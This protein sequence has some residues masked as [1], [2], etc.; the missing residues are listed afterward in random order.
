MPGEECAFTT[1]SVSV[2]VTPGTPLR[3]V[4][5]YHVNRF[6]IAEADGL[7][8]IADLG[9]VLEAAGAFTGTTVIYDGA[10]QAVVSAEARMVGEVRAVLAAFDW[11]HDDRQL[12]LEAI[13]R[14]DDED[15]ADEPEDDHWRDYNYACS[16]CGA[17]IGMFIGRQGWAALPRRRHCGQPGRDLRRRPRGHVRRRTGRCAVTGAWP[18]FSLCLHGLDAGKIRLR[19]DERHN[20]VPRSRRGRRDPG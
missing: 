19:R 9:A 2:P 1:V 3:R 5:G 12:A 10:P 13:E 15:Q 14:I 17:L 16:T 6:A 8:T 4:R 20:A 18:H 11:E 7:I